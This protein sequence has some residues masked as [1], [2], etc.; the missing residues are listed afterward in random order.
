MREF[1]IL[2]RKPALH[3]SFVTD[4]GVKN[5]QCDVLYGWATKDYRYCPISN[6]FAL[7]KLNEK[8]VLI[9]ITE[10]L[11]KNSLYKTPQSAYIKQKIKSANNLNLTAI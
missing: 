6:L 5:F 9:R 1:N 11:S 10:H 3:N 7:S 4:G 8:I 2:N